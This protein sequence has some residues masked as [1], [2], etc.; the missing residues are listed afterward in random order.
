VREKFKTLVSFSYL[1]AC[2]SFSSDRFRIARALIKAI[3]SA[4]YPDALYQ[5]NL[6]V[7]RVKGFRMS[8]R[9]FRRLLFS[10]NERAYIKMISCA[11]QCE[12]EERKEGVNYPRTL[13]RLY[14]SNSCPANEITRNTIRC[15]RGLCLGFFLQLLSV[16]S[17]AV[18][19]C[20]SRPLCSRYQCFY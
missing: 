10:C 16:R 7:A 1:T 12:K 5:T 15:H 8:Y 19:L 11:R 4:T 18:S 2:N 6:M 9:F 17:A 13:Y 14:T 20:F 3:T